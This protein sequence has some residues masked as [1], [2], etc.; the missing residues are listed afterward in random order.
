[1]KN[2]AIFGANGTIGQA[3]ID[4]L[5]TEHPSASI[6]TF[7]RQTT[8]DIIL[9]QSVQHNIVDYTNE[10]SLKQAADSLPKTVTFDLIIVATG[11]LHSDSVQ[12]EKSYK[13]MDVQKF[14]T[15]FAANTIT[16]AMIAKHFIPKLNKSDIA[17]F[18]A[19]SA[20]IG[21]ISDNKLGGWHAYR[22]SKAALNMIIKNIAVETQLRSKQS[23]I[24]GLHPGTVDSPL[25][26]PFQ[27]NI[28]SKNLFEPKT[29][30]DYLYNVIKQLNPEDSGK[31][32]AWD[33]SIIEP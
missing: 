23:I 7:S 5:N 30:A 13:Q 22:A 12:P 18:A 9:K 19:L 16:P 11:I 32:F 28:P 3:L 4:K 24:V 29:S 26:K 27:K 6:Y 2:I 21:S 31:C 25:S 8:P 15:L 20:R 14:E 17:V 1:M 33:G 10:D